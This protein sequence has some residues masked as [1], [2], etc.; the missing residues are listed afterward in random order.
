MPLT[1]P[2]YSERIWTAG[3]AVSCD[4]SLLCDEGPVRTPGQCCSGSP[5]DDQAMPKCSHPQLGLGLL[6]LLQTTLPS[7]YH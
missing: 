7:N 2:S 1:Q 3:V 5:P 6:R 4:S